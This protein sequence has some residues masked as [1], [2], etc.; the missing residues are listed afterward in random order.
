[1]LAEAERRQGDEDAAIETL[2]EWHR[3]GGHEPET[4]LSLAAGLRERER[5]AEAARVLESLNWV[6]PY[7]ADAHR[8][9]GEHYLDDGR[10]DRARI[11]FEALLG[12]RPEDPATAW[13]GKALAARALDDPERARREV[14][15]ALE[16]APFY[17]PAQRLLLELVS[18]E[19]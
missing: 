7:D 9:L 15:Y 2:L 19:S 8:W 11:E 13:L 6:M 1:M 18:G 4:L 3:L 10:P 12:L 5:A 16:S 17:R 14:L